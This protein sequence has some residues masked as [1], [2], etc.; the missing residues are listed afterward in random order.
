MTNEIFLII[1]ISCG[2]FGWCWVD[3]LTVD[4]AIFD[5]V[6]RYYPI[7]FEKWT[8]CSKCLAARLSILVSCIY[9]ICNY[10][11][12]NLFDI[13]YLVLMPMFTMAVVKLLDN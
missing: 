11:L 3:V 2:V 5:K 9:Y 4:R 13:L 6:K 8:S 10:E 1:A 12:C 7:K